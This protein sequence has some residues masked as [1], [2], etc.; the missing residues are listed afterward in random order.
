MNIEFVEFY[1]LKRREKNKKTRSVLGTVHV[2][3]I[4]DEIDLRGIVAK[5]AGKGIFFQFPHFQTVDIETDEPVSYPYLRFSNPEKQ[6]A[7]MDFLHQI[8][9]PLIKQRPEFNK[10][11]YVR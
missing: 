8:V 5:K 11:S 6:K 3:I 2:K 9:K 10:T 4:D 7:L 1:P